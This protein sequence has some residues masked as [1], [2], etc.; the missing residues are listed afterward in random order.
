MMRLAAWIRTGAVAILGVGFA[1]TLMAD[2]SPDPISLMKKDLTYLAGDECEGRGVETQGI[3]KA[4][5]YIAAKFK[6][7]GL[8]PGGVDGTYFQ[9]FPIAGNTVLGK[10]NTLTVR[11]PKGETT[12]LK[13]GTDFEVMGLSGSG[14]L[15]ADVVL[16]GFGITLP[17]SKYDDLA[18][19]DVAGKVVLV[20]RKVPGAGTDK[21]LV[22][23]G[24]PA[25]SFVAK[26]QALAEKKP[27]AVIFVNDLSSIDKNDPLVPFNTLLGAGRSLNFP[28]LFLK[29][30][31]VD[32][33]L[34]SLG[35]PDLKQYETQITES[36]K[37]NSLALTGW[38][39]GIETEVTRQDIQAK[40]ILGVLEGSGPLKDQTIIIGAHYDHLG[41][42]ERGS[43]ARSAE[44]R[45]KIH[46]G[47][48]DN[49]SGTTT[50]LE[51]ARR[52]AGMK[53]RQG[54]RIVFMLFSGEERGLLGSAYYCQK[55]PLFPLESTASM[56]NLDMVGRLR[57]DKIQVWGT[58]SS[59][60]FDSLFEKLNKDF[61]FKAQKIPS[62]G[63]PSDHASFNGKNIPVFFLFTDLHDQYH[64][65]TDTVDTINFEGMAKIANFSERLATELATMPERPVFAKTGSAPRPGGRPSVPSIK[66]APGSYAEDDK[67]VL[68]GDVREGGPAAKAGLKGG[69][70]IVGIAGKPVKNMEDY[71]TVMATQK[72]GKEVEFTVQ[73][74]KK[75]LKL[76]VTPE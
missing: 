69:D 70:F 65:P 22:D 3:N 12:E 13:R 58:G 72:A 57:D 66:F 36:K 30:A 51:L 54:R 29:R 16:A 45:K 40:N 68:V 19:L 47:A 14:K 59:P 44:D 9:P 67:G 33:M 46:Y 11:S 7:L 63:G 75:T 26:L 28:V 52:F 49:G 27:A 31:T 20:L 21:A 62:G 60:G 50:V 61:G 10:T 41:Y 37:P 71:M 8:K 55:Q 38:K 73:R 17:E 35:K 39:L 32:Q 2:S 18:G 15:N 53:D 42:G 43:L 6:D 56:L 74:D 64:R 48:D 34:K 1:S 23:N 25:A 5:D 76:K 24:N 4:A